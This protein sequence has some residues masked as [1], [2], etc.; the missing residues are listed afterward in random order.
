MALATSPGAAWRGRCQRSRWRR[1]TARRRR[2]ATRRLPL[3][4]KPRRCACAM[5]TLGERDAAGRFAFDGGVVAGGPIPVHSPPHRDQYGLHTERLCKRYISRCLPPR[6]AE[7]KDLLGEDAK[8]DRPEVG[9]NADGESRGC[10]DGSPHRGADPRIHEAA[11]RRASPHR[12]ATCRAG[13][14]AASTAPAPPP[15]DR[16]RSTP[17]RRRRERRGR[18]PGDLSPLIALTYVRQEP[19]SSTRT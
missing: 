5:D 17:A 8:A 11:S 18:P 6:R 19:H 3:V 10:T 1:E 14:C 15:R 13:S 2:R 12:G 4:S 9:G 7:P 16:D